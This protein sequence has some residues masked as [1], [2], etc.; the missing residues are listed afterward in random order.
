MRCDTN[1]TTDT[2]TLEDYNITGFT[3]VTT[4]NLSVLNNVVQMQDKEDID[5]FEKLQ[6]LIDEINNTPPI[7]TMIGNSTI[8]L[9]IND[10][11]IE[12]GAIATDNVDGNI[13]NNIVTI[14]EVNSSSIGTYVLIYSI[15]DNSGNEANV[16]RSVRV[17]DNPPILRDINIS[18]ME[19]SK[20]MFLG[21]IIVSSNSYIES[22]RLEGDGANNFTFYYYGELYLAY[23]ADIDYEVAKEFNLT[24]YATNETS[25]SVGV[26]IH[27]SVLDIHHLVLL[28]TP[29][30]SDGNV[31]FKV[32]GQEVIGETLFINGVD[33]GII[34]DEN[35]TQVNMEQ[36]DN[37]TYLLTSYL[38]LNPIFTAGINKTFDLT[39]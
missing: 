21:N 20:D 1:G 15:V 8:N 16:T 5:T 36:E 11:Y 33:S 35:T 23:G 18:I 25:E 38:S 14:G 6:M 39:S 37:A 26:N 3:G 27:I 13:T 19:N 12:E 2:P 28:E 7:I 10:N 17:L 24:A 31:S 22:L 30:Y 34:L 32:Q 9:N 4:L 29:I